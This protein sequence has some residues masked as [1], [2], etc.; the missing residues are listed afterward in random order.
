EK[1]NSDVLVIN[2]SGLSAEVSNHRH[3]RLLRPCRD[4]PRHRS[5]EPRNELP[6]PHWLCLQAARAAAYPGRGC[7]GTGY[8]AGLVI[9][10]NSKR[11]HVG[12]VYGAR[13]GAQP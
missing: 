4:R 12:S 13:G 8:V 10:I 3:R 5:A 9:S 6:P 1:R 11:E 7:R 2:I